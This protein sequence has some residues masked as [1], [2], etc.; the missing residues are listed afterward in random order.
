MLNGYKFLALPRLMRVLAF[1]LK[2]SWALPSCSGTKSWAG[3]LSAQAQCKGS[4]SSPQ[5]GTGWPGTP[6]STCPAAPCWK[7]FLVSC[8]DRWVSLAL[9][10]SWSSLLFHLMVCQSSGC[11]TPTLVQGHRWD[12]LPV[13]L[14]FLP[15][16]TVIFVE[17][18]QMSNL[19]GLGL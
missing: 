4:S 3:S 1:V 13:C 9:T 2:T 10:S 11:R 16:L 18:S 7:Q 6:S 19:L 17:S 12:L 8:L 14:I 15:S 5:W